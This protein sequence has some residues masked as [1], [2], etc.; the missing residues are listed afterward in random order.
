VERGHACW[1]D[2]FRSDDASRPPIYQFELVRSLRRWK[3][4]HARALKRKPDSFDQV[5]ATLKSGLPSL[6]NE[7]TRSRAAPITCRGYLTSYALNLAASKMRF[8]IVTFKA[9]EKNDAPALQYESA[10]AGGSSGRQIN[11][12]DFGSIWRKGCPVHS[13]ETSALFSVPK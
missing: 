5:V 10:C 13:F 2:E 9:L 11:S 12:N 7:P 3:I 1:P 4:A 8:L 6:G